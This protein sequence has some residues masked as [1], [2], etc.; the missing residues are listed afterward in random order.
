MKHHICELEVTQEWLI[1]ESIDYIAECLHACESAEM[2]ADLRAIFPR[3]ALRCASI[4]VSNP[5]RSRLVEW[6]EVLH[7]EE[8]AA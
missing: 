6:L 7:Q 3:Q 4:K 1:M 8:K 5:Q 2:V